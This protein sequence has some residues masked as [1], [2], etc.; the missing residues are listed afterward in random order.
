M[1]DLLRRQVAT[2]KTMAKYRHRAFDWRNR[3]SCI[4]M[5]RFHM[6]QM[7]HRPPAVPD[8]RSALGALRALERTGF[9][10]VA[11]LFD[12]LAPRIAPAAMLLGDIAVC[13]GDDGLDAILI[14]AGGKM[15]GWH[16]DDESG[17]KPLI[18][19]ELVGAWR[20]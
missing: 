12:S 4:H 10:D 15:L 13:P 2:Q 5:A 11:A 14:S 9:A 7:G 18:V 20:L 16:Q 19:S 1:S 6:R 3:A 8:F 17:L